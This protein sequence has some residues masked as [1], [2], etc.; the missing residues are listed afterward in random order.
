MRVQWVQGY[1]YARPRPLAVVLDE[2]AA[3]YAGPG[4]G[5]R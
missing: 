4:R 2:A 5:T 3:R 1:L